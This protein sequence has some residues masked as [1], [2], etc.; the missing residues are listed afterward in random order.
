LAA[1]PGAPTNCVDGNTGPLCG[2][3]LSGYALQSGECAPCDSGSAWSDWSAAR[4]GTLLAFTLAFAVA[5]V[6]V[7]FCMPLLPNVE[8][9]VHGYMAAFHAWVTSV[10]KRGT[11]CKS[12]LTCGL[13]GPH[14]HK[15]AGAAENGDDA[16]TT[17]RHDS[18][19]KRGVNDG[20]STP[21]KPKSAEGTEKNEDQAEE[22]KAD[23]AH[24]AQEKAEGSASEESVADDVFETLEE[25]MGLI[26]QVQALV[27]KVQGFAKI[28]VK[29]APPPVRPSQ[30]LLLTPNACIC[31]HSTAS[32]RSRPRFSRAWTCRGRARSATAWPVQAS[33][34]ST[35]CSCLRRRACIPTSAITPSSTA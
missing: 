26:D 32:T 6:P 21:D 8:E 14:K 3:C 22:T 10:Q 29:Y 13:A 2:V 12:C 19:L 15:D 28:L 20:S 25:G 18:L 35:W 31:L 11:Q 1:T 34:T 24:D 16:S 23:E 27:S 5:C 4:K 17:I 33:S 7:V 30:L 9:R